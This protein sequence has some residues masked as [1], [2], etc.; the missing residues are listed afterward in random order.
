MIDLL[1]GILTLHGNGRCHIYRPRWG[2]VTRSS[3]C[4]CPE[5]HKCVL[6]IFKRKDFVLSDLMV[7]F[8]KTRFQ[9]LYSRGVEGLRTMKRGTGRDVEWNFP[10]LFERTVSVVARRNAFRSSS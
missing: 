4:V 2:E 1:S 9:F 3:L 7:G 8:L 10:A 5:L 6:I